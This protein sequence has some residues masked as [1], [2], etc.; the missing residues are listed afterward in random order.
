MSA[1]GV[2]RTSRY[3]PKWA[4][5]EHL[6]EEIGIRPGG[7][8]P[9]DMAQLGRLLGHTCTPRQFVSKEDWEKF[10][11]SEPVRKILPAPRVDLDKADFQTIWQDSKVKVEFA[12]E[13]GRRHLLVSPTDPLPFEEEAIVK[14]EP[15]FVAVQRTVS[16]VASAFKKI[17]PTPDYAQT[18]VAREKTFSIDLL[19]LGESLKKPIS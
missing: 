7:Q 2:D 18:I 17:F 11:A 1:L 13:N 14:N 12:T 3:Q 6:A 10:V 19:Q 9:V 16:Y 5:G 15:Q 8:N 4:I